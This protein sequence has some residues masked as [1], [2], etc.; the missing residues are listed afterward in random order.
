MRETFGGFRFWKKAK[1]KLDKKD[2][3]RKMIAEREK[4]FERTK[5]KKETEYQEKMEYYEQKIKYYNEE[6]SK[7]QV[8]LRDKMSRVRVRGRRGSDGMIK[9]GWFVEDYHDD[10][11]KMI[12]K[13]K[14]QREE[15]PYD[16][17]VTRDRLH[18]SFIWDRYHFAEADNIA[19]I[20]KIDPTDK[21]VDLGEQ[22][23]KYLNHKKKAEKAD[24]KD[25]N[26]DDT[27]DSADDFLYQATQDL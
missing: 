22:I 1:V 23:Q 27:F 21:N 6:Y 3:E 5:K 26:V 16:I 17:P 19:D 14:L 11:A 18:Y 2:Q 7:E 8:K 15:N 12:E 9:V 10:L 4:F 20:I 13:K 25:K 24:K